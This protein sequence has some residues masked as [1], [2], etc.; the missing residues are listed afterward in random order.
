MRKLLGFLL[1]A[2]TVSCGKNEVIYPYAMNQ[3]LN[4]APY[5]GNGFSPSG[6]GGFSPQLPS[7]YPSAYTPF[8]PID[9]YMRG[10]PQ[11][12]GYWQSHWMNW[13]SHCSQRGY[14]PYDFNQFWFSYTP[15]QW[16]NTGFYPLYQQFNQSF[17]GWA[18]PQVQYASG[19]SPAN[20][21]F[22]YQGMSYQSW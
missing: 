2:F 3:P 6:N 10:N 14:S 4:Q 15:Q 20:F 5:M 7:G 13:R 18:N 16:Q 1:V 11:L 21:W 12:A 19:L 8:L 22:N 9:N 17:Y